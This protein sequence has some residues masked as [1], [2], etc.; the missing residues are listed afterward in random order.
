MIQVSKRYVLILLC[1]NLRHIRIHCKLVYDT[2]S[3]NSIIMKTNWHI[4]IIYI[5]METNGKFVLLS[6]EKNRITTTTIVDFH[7]KRFKKKKLLS[8]II[9]TIIIIITRSM[10]APISGVIFNNDI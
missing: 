6:W 3:Y 8:H 7:R 9:F 2:R 4:H 10:E 5:F 1:T